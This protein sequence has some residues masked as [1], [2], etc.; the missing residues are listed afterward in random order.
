MKYLNNNPFVLGKDIPTELFCDRKQETDTLV[1]QIVNHWCL[2]TN[3][4]LVR[5]IL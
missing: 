3:V 1:K 5:N 2:L 4:N